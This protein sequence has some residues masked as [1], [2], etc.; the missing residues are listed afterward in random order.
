MY[1][2]QGNLYKFVILIFLNIDY[3]SYIGYI[4]Y[5]LSFMMIL[6]QGIPRRVVN[7]S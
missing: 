3:I 6:H 7:A 2:A 5:I 1:I 4:G